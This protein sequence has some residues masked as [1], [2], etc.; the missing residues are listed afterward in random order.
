M[1]L[2]LYGLSAHINAF[3]PETLTG[4]FFRSV[5][6]VFNENKIDVRL[7]MPKYG[8]ISD[9]KFI[10]REV[11]RLKEIPV[12]VADEEIVTSVKSA[13]IPD[14][15]VQTYFVVYPPYFK[16][17]V[18][19][20]GRN[21]NPSDYEKFDESML[22]FNITGMRTLEYL[23]WKPDLIFAANWHSALSPILLATR[24][25]DNEWYAQSKSVLVLS[26]D[27]P[28]RAFSP[29]VLKA[30]GVSDADYDISKPLEYLKASIRHASAVLIMN[31][32]GEKD[33]LKDLLADSDVKKLLKSKGELF[34][35]VT[36]EKPDEEETWGYLAQDFYQFLESIQ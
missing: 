35:T 32:A 5:S 33:E 30:F 17:F 8:A 3:S 9:R 11:I 27:E 13:F 2:K 28:F 16:K 4:E 36:I 24:Y 21:F 26:S 23:Y 22:L 18:A 1:A 10:L 7:F 25:A 12:M 14:T 34:K 19:P 29:D 15:K 6:K 31:V 20:F